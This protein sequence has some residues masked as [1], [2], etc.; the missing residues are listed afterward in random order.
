MGIYKG[1]KLAQEN[2]LDVAKFCTMAAIKAPQITGKVK[3][4]TEVIT[5]EDIDPIEEILKIQGKTNIVAEGDYNT[6][7]YYREQKKRPVIL[8]VGA[9]NLRQC[10]LE[11]DCGA[12]G[13]ST[14]EEFNKYSDSV[15]DEVSK[16]R[17]RYHLGPQCPWKQM[18]LGSALCWAC[19]AAAQHSVENRMIAS[20]WNVAKLVGYMEEAHSGAALCLGPVE[21]LVYYDRPSL[22]GKWTAQEHMEFLFR[23]MPSHFMG[24]TGVKDPRFKYGDEWEKKPKRVRIEA[25][26]KEYFAELAEDENKIDQ[27]CARVKAKLKAKKGKK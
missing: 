8:L 1:N 26:S 20:I 6:L 5:D 23:A 18:D 21:N 13:F 25:R 11:W 24:F 16:L 12:C 9:P 3:V 22:R 7:K 2:L 4:V 14:C 15:A 10:E 17:R 27:I 19:A